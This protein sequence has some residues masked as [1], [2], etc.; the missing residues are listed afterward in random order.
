MVSVH[1]SVNGE[2]ERMGQEGGRI[3]FVTYLKAHK[4]A[5]YVLGAMV[6]VHLS[7]QYDRY[8]FSVSKIPFMDY[9]SFEF[10]LIAGPFFTAVNATAGVLLSFVGDVRPVRLLST[11]CLVWSACT[12]AVAF[13]RTYWQVALTRVG[14]GIGDAACCPFAASIL[15]DHFGPE[16]IGSAMGVF[17]VGLFA[18]FSLSLGGGTLIDDLLG[19]RWAYFLAASAGFVA[20]AITYVTVQEPKKSLAA[21]AGLLRQR[22]GYSAASAATTKAP[23]AADATAADGPGSVSRRG[24]GGGGSGGGGF[25]PVPSPTYSL[26]RREEEGGEGGKQALREYGDAAAG[27]ESKEDRRADADGSLEDGEK[28]FQQQQ[29]QQQQQQLMNGSIHRPPSSIGGKMGK[30]QDLSEAWL[31]SPSL[32]LICLAGGIRDAGG[33]VFSYYLASYFSPL[34]DGNAVL[35]NDGPCSFSYDASFNGTQVCDES[36]PWCIDGS[37]NT[38]SS[39]PWHDIGMPASHLEL[40]VSWVP[41]VGGSLGA[42]MGGI[43]S[44]RIAKEYGTA[45]RLWVVVVSNAI[46]TP[47]AVGVLLAPYPWC[48]LCLLVVSLVGEMW[49]GIMVTCIMTLVPRHV[50]VTSVALYNF[51]ITNLSGLC[52]LLV[53]PIR[54]SYDSPHLFSFFAEPL[55]GAAAAGAA[56]AAA[57]AAAFAGG[58]SGSAAEGEGGDATPLSLDGLLGE[59]GSMAGYD[60]EGWSGDEFGGGA[61][62]VEPVEFRLSAPGST[63]LRAAMMWI[64]PGLFLA[65]SFFCLAAI[66]ALH[67]DKQEEEAAAADA[68][69]AAAVEAD[70]EPLAGG[71]GDGENDGDGW[72]SPT[73]T[74]WEVRSAAAEAAAAARIPARSRGP[75]RVF[76]RGVRN[77]TGGGGGGG[78]GTSGFASGGAGTEGLEAPLLRGAGEASDAGRPTSPTQP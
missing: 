59:G 18:G 28:G 23:I 10:A 7:S 17:Y 1:G 35:T 48:F 32:L 44:D 58:E 13:S 22:R 11:A 19:W 15:R 72:S 29:V 34:M 5:A 51:F 66:V 42:M 31:G 53:P 76:G 33:F 57:A 26:V 46:A 61:A 77:L 73:T 78:G 38:L 50:R 14:Q 20:A 30:M 52:T 71:G 25:R 6:M 67:Q 56:T 36:Y 37:C 12:G 64:Y 39:S 75:K 63:G 47:F 27:G 16:V 70:Y 21:G 49:I 24:P 55:A 65:S 43:L 68:A 69:V 41:L 60:G 4:R 3:R 9:E 54:A 62:E 40:F 2:G 8:L 74:R 45:G